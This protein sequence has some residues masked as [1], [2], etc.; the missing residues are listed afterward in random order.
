M[1]CGENGPLPRRVILGWIA[2]FTQA[3][4][5]FSPFQAVP[6]V[7]R[8]SFVVSSGRFEGARGKGSRGDRNRSPQFV[9]YNGEISHVPVAFL[10]SAVV[11]DESRRSGG[12]RRRREKSCANEVCLRFDTVSLL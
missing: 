5:E 3:R 9:L 2:A 1:A 11:P 7:A 4:E 10:L 6:Q 12:S 8:R